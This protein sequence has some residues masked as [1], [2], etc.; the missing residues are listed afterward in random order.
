MIFIQLTGNKTGD[1][2]TTALSEAL[3]TNSSLTKLELWGKHENKT[4]NICFNYQWFIS[5]K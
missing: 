4:L 2:G 1:S 5:R 3:K